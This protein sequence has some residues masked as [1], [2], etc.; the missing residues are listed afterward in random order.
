LAYEI[1]TPSYVG[2]ASR[3]D[4]GYS[5]IRGIAFF[6]LADLDGACVHWPKIHGG[7]KY[8][9]FESSANTSRVDGRASAYPGFVV[10]RVPTMAGGWG[11][12]RN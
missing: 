4:R 6:P 9:A 10:T 7:K 3:S 5:V 2:R 8:T 11:G 12:G 1:N